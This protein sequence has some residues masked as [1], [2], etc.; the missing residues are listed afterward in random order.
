MKTRSLRQRHR[1][2]KKQYLAQLKTRYPACKHDEDRSDRDLYTGHDITYGEM[3]YTGI[4]ALYKHLVK[5]YN[6]NINAFID[7]GS[8]RGK[9]CMYM[10]GHPKIKHVLGIEL[11][12]QRHDDALH[13]KDLLAKEYAK[14][15]ELVNENVLAVDFETFREAN[16]FVW[17]SN[18]CFD[19]STTNSIFHKLYEE[20]PKGTILCCSKVFD[21]KNEIN[22]TKEYEYIESIPIE[23]SWTK[24]SN[25]YIYKTV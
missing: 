17:F 4:E 21:T 20:L 5:K 15:V 11:V 12:K 18:L 7:V 1:T 2:T 10:A 24:S 14:K 3:E 9:L 6:S 8:G 16:V 13:L 22:R 23:M 25:V 19:Q